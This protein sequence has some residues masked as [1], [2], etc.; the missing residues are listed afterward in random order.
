MATTTQD[1]LLL[2]LTS[3]LNSYFIALQFNK[4]IWPAVLM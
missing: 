2:V 1:H 4:L 3:D